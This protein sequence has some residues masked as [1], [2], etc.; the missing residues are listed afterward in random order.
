MVG[1]VQN[2]AR[3]RRTGWRRHETRT[4]SPNCVPGLDGRGR[5]DRPFT[6]DYA[7]LLTYLKLGS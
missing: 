1:A 3:R 5:A 4:R 2:L 6:D 7:D